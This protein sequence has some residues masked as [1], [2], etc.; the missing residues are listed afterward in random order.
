MWRVPLCLR[1]TARVDQ[2]A[3]SQ[4]GNPAQADRRQGLSLAFV[5][6]LMRSAPAYNEPVSWQKA[7]GLALLHAGIVLGSQR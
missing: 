6:V 5:L 4:R 3:A 7:A 2:L 1:S